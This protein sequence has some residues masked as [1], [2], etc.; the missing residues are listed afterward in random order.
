N[1]HVS[2]ILLANTFQI[3]RS[4]EYHKQSNANLG[5]HLGYNYANRYYAD[6]SSAIPHSAKLPE[7]NRKAFSPT[8]SLAWRLSEEEFMKGGAFN[9]LRLKASAGIVN[10]D[11]DI[12]QFYLYQGYYTFNNAAWYSWRDGELIRTFDRFRGENMNMGYPQ[13]RELNIGFEASMFNN[14]ISYNATYFYNQMNGL[15]VQPSTL[16]PMYFMSY[17]P[18]YSDLP[19]V[20]YNIDERKGVDFGVNFNKSFYNSSLS[21]GV[22]GLYYDTKA[23]KR[24]ELYEFDYQNRTGKPLDAMWGLQSNGFY[25]DQADIENSAVSTFG[26]VKP[27]DI[28]Y[29]DQ[30]GDGTIDD[31]DEVYLGKGGWAGAPFSLGFNLTAKWKNLTLFAVAT[32]RYGS[33]AMRNNS[34]FWVD[35]ED[36]YSITVRD[37]WTP[38][39]SSTAT[40]P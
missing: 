11:L 20:N 31:R 18:V 24:D 28:K 10:T 40:Y 2:A 27:G 6:F 13:R 29:I 5:L 8:L 16:Y 23:S 36:K 22:T 3:G 19:Y 35:G 26:E 37:R 1:H 38:E 15:L 17:W 39:T 25:S 32:S 30:N 4:A 9:D 33:Y 7:G 12:E 14:L 34:Y 21:F